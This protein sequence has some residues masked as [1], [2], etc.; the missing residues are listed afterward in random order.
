MREL[1]SQELSFVSGGLSLDPAVRPSMRRP[2]RVRELLSRI[3]L[4]SPRGLAASSRL[5]LQ[6]CS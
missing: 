6:L 2:V 1:T 5:S 3:F 4:R